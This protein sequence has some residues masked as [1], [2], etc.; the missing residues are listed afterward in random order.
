MGAKSAK[1]EATPIWGNGHSASVCNHNRLKFMKEKP[2]SCFKRLA[3]VGT[4]K[5]AD[6]VKYS[7][8][9]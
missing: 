5:K 3:T 4:E 7:F 9:F 2:L 6:H 1:A 8:R